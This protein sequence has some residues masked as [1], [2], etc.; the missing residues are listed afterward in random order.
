MKTINELNYNELTSVIADALYSVSVGEQLPNIMGITTDEVT[1]NN[2]QTVEVYCDDE[3]TRQ[4]F[5]SPELEQVIAVMT[6]ALYKRE[7]RDSLKL[8]MKNRRKESN[9]RDE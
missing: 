6:V 4:L 2:L 7:S 8:A 5:W 3:R 1:T 9:M